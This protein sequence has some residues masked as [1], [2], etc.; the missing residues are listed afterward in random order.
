VPQIHEIGRAYVQF[1]TL[2]PG[3]PILHTAPT[4]ETEP[5]YRVGAS[6][7]VRCWPATFAVVVGRWTGRVNVPEHAELLALRSVL[8]PRSSGPLD[9]CSTCGTNLACE[10]LPE[11]DDDPGHCPRCLQAWDC[12]VCLDALNDTYARTGSR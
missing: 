2:N 11:Y 9:W 7:I 12:C 3:A 8:V 4:Y 1:L 10:C 5:P 6:L